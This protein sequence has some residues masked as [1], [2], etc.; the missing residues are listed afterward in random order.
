MCESLLPAL[1]MI[2]SGHPGFTDD[3]RRAL[4]L[5]AECALE[6]ITDLLER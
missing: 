6:A 2:N 3:E 4:L 1:R 5:D